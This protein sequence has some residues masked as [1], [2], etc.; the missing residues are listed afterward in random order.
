MMLS[1]IRVLEFGQNVAGP[2]GASILCDLGAEVIKIEPPS[3]DHNRSRRPVRSGF[4]SFC[5]RATPT[6]P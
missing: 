1:G 6:P 3:G 4:S 2:Y 5:G